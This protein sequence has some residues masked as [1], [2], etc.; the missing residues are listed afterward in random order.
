[1]AKIFDPNANIPEEAEKKPSSGL[2]VTIMVAIIFTIILVLMAIEKKREIDKENKIMNLVELLVMD[3]GN[4]L[5]Q[6]VRYATSKKVDPKDT[7]DLF[8]EVVNG[9]DDFEKGDL[10]KFNHRFIQEEQIE[11]KT[12]CLIPANQVHF[13]LKAKDVKKDILKRNK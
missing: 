5:T 2:A 3:N 9:N 13:H 4:I 11:N 7:S 12:Y 10:I 1:M 8:F 6:E